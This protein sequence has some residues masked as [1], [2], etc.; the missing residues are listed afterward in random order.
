MRDFFIGSLEKLITIIVVLLVIG[1]VIGA[2]A[3]M[4]QQGILAGVAVLVAGSVYSVLVGGMLYIGV[5]I[6]DNT[7]RT[8]DA[9][10]RLSNK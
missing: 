7:K 10:E 5:G 6:Y 2:L 3:A 4:A 9:V 1:T 8:A